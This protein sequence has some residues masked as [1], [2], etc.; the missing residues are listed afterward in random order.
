MEG[1]GRG[2]WRGGER[3]VKGNFFSFFFF[4][5]WKRDFISFKTSFDVYVDTF[6]PVFLY[7]RFFLFILELR[8]KKGGFF[9]GNISFF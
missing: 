6:F 3:G 5:Y 4:A 7:T 8:K 2:E 9:F 1:E